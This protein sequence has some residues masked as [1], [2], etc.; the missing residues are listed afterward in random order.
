MKISY[1]WLKQYINTDK[2]AEQVAE[3]LTNCGL[4]IE[5]IEQFETIKGGL[6]GVIV[7]HVMSVNQHPNADRL[8]CCKVNIGDQTLDIVCGAPNVAEG[9]KVPVATIGTQ[10]YFSNGETIT[11]KKG[12]IRGEESYGMICSEDE[13]G[14]SNSHD[15]ILVL[16]ENVEVGTALAD[17]FEIEN[18]TILE[19]AITP[20]RGD[21]TSHIGVARDLNAVLNCQ[22][23]ETESKLVIPSVD[24]FKI[25]NNNLEI[26]VEVIDSNACIRY[27]GLSMT[28]I[29]VKESPEWLK[30]KL[31]SIGLRPIN[32]IV[33]ITNY[34]M[35]EIGQPLHAFDA[36]KIKGNKV[37]VKKLS[38]DFPFTTL[39]E[40]ER[41]LSENDLMIC[42]AE[43]PMCI[44]GVFGGIAS[45]VT[46][47]TKAIFIESAC[48]EQA[49]VR[50][51]AKYHGLKTDASF[52]FERGTDPEAT[53]Y[54]LKRAAN[55][56]KEIAGGEV[57]SMVYDVY[58]NP[59]ERKKL[60]LS[61]DKV[62]RLIGIKIP[63]DTICNILNSLDFNVLEKDEKE[64]FL[65]IPTAKT[66]VTRA[67][68]V[69]E[70]ILRVFG[71]NNV[72]YNEH[73]TMSLSHGKKP[74]PESLRN[75]VSQYLCHNG[76]SEIM[77]NSLTAE[78][79][80]SKSETYKIDE[81]VKILNPLSQ[82]LNVMRQTLMFSAL[83]SVVHNH[84]R[85]INDTKFY[86]FGTVYKFNRNTN[87][88]DK[89]S[90]YSEK[91]ALSII[92]SGGQNPESWYNT[93]KVAVDY[94][95]IKSHVFDLLRK[96]GFPYFKMEP[97]QIGH[98][99][100]VFGEKFDLYGQTLVEIGKLNSKTLSQFGIKQDVYYA[101][102][103]WG[104]ILENLEYAK[105]INKPISK[106]P[107]V[108]R[109]L[110]IIVKK[111]V[112]FI[113]IEKLAYDTVKKLLT[114]V[115]LF[116]IFEGKQIGEENKS[117][118]LRFHFQNLERTLTDK[119]IESSM[120]RLMQA[121]EKELGA[122]IRK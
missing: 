21:A 115:S 79:Y 76:F 111:N 98:E 83:E 118:A 56:I 77:T 46:E 1:N 67:E 30:N 54:A 28:G 17:Y 100:F 50:K 55:L 72:P 20:N 65:S 121:F 33:D 120:N 119:E 10:L 22:N 71:Y 101:E 53:V 9:Q 114:Q 113:D 81:C 89:L 69:I 14:I 106:Y 42:N 90:K 15:G 34:V 25:D 107:E 7:G 40:V 68:D 61:F 58:P 108:E 60:K 105:V 43:E 99:F 110:A 47:N 116:D 57:S 64:L 51:T 11:I 78:A 96:I 36:S 44:A 35:M 122:V 26:P 80:Y 102:I 95:F 27:S 13:L 16:P 91:Q 112:N 62:E 59:I 104:K 85:K 87:S 86:E 39:D 41:K 23:P 88:E 45:G 75:I 63:N 84:N 70:E 5:Q 19:V 32:N 6:K 18:D 38:Q 31:K 74:N 66:E 24:E 37:V 29:T 93:S 48:F 52:R 49:H 103:Q 117:Y 92:C 94:T 109:D 2:S 73:V 8:K 4:E 3:M 12:K 82:E 97:D